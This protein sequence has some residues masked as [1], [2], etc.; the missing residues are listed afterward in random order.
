MDFI[1]LYIDPSVMSY[2]IQIVAGAVI[3]IG[4]IVGVV[5]RRMKKN[6]K[7]SLNIDENKNKEVEDEIVFTDTDKD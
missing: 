5:F 7:K 1:K 6:V 2:T 3:T 4:A